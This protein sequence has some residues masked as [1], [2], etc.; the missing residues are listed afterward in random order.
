MLIG[1]NGLYEG[2]NRG[3]LI[4]EI[5]VVA[6]D[7]TRRV[8]A[9]A[10][11]GRELNTTTPDPNDTIAKYEV[12]YAARGNV[13]TV[14]AS[15]N[16]ADPLQFRRTTPSGAATITD[17]K[18]DP[19]NWQIAYA[20]DA[21]HLYKTVDGGQ[22]WDDVSGFLPIRELRTLEL[23]KT[24]AGDHV[25]LVG[26]QGGVYRTTNPNFLS[27]WTEF[28][29]GLPNVLVT[30][31]EYNAPANLLYVATFGRGAWTISN[32]SAALNQASK[33]EINGDGA[34]DTVRLV[35]NANNPLM[36][37]VF[38]NNAGVNPTLRIAMPTMEQIIFRGG[39]GDDTLTIDTTNGVIELPLDITFE[40]DANTDHLIINGPAINFG[41]FGPDGDGFTVTVAASGEDN[42]T[43]KYRNVE[44]VQNSL[45][46][47][48]D[49][50][51]TVGSGLNAM[52]SSLNTSDAL[53]LNFPAL[54]SSLGRALAGEPV[55]QPDP[56]GTR[57]DIAV[58]RTLRAEGSDIIRRMIEDGLGGFSI[59]DIGSKIASADALREKLDALDSTPNNVVFTDINGV[60]RF[61][62]EV[63]KSLSG[64]ADLELSA[65]DGAVSLG[66]V[67][68]AAAD[69]VMHVVFGVDDK[70]FFIEAS[71]AGEPLVSV[72]NVRISG[73]VQGTGKFG[74]LEV[75]VED[76]T[77]TVD[78]DVRINVQLTEPGVDPHTG[79]TDGLIRLYELRSVSELF[80]VT[81][82]G[83][84]TVDDVVLNVTAEV[85][86]LLPS[87]IPPFTLGNAQVTARWADVT[88][89]AT[90]TVTASAGPG[91]ELLNF[92]EAT[93]TQ[94]VSGI[95]NL[96]AFTNQIAG[97]DL[98]AVKIPLVDKTLGEI[99]GGTADELAIN[100][101]SVVD[102]SPESIQETYKKFTVTLSEINLQELSVAIGDEVLYQDTTN[103]ARTA[104]VDSV[105]GGKLARALPE[106]QSDATPARDGA[107]L[108]GAARR[109]AGA[110]VAIDS[111]QIR[112]PS[113]GDA[114]DPDAAKPGKGV[115]RPDRRGRFRDRPDG[116]R[117]GGEPRDRDH[118]GVRS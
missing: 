67:V 25:V 18:L 21:T 19:S 106:R 49:R 3:D 41:T 23:Y 70:G 79:V 62:V 116:E 55:V 7:G 118:A 22:T 108:Q 53:A 76:A 34:A 39:G 92:L 16:A 109:I 6:A 99:L 33:L 66:G 4:T 20:V 51:I 58:F 2:T 102:I 40:G 90:L 38:V 1:Y 56:T 44:D 31:V 100:N 47:T 78:P 11:G 110:A 89:P 114:G 97:I 35:R 29:A 72:E 96:A 8:T 107:Q 28:G 32:A 82:T 30:E 113:D 87:G 15:L 13:I 81:V 52:T 42:Q 48:I 57:S 103:T 64:D 60:T 75:T 37:D 101:A 43:V 117:H 105:D 115:G 63:R 61:D 98:M 112:E 27:T 9:L 88:D 54:G 45:L 93:T 36:V 95:S 91:Q 104:T 65:L 71:A 111:G 14:R 68:R 17:I 86:A 46:G 84:P 69:L 77:L 10:Y 83:D 80:D 50:L 24:A 26:G 73:N 74:F 12:Y 5:P 94:I 59:Q 85:A